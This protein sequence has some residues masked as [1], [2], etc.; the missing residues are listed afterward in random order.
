MNEIWMALAPIL[1]ADVLNPV[2]FAFMVY[3]VS[4]Q[5]PIINSTAILLGHTLAYFSAGIIIALGLE[6]ISVRLANP[7]SIDF[8]ISLLIGILLLWVAFRSTKKTD[9]QQNKKNTKLTP[10]KALCLGAVVNFVGI[11]F[12]LPYFA[13]LDQILKANLAMT[14]SLLILISYNLLYALPFVIVPILVIVIGER[15]KPLLQRINDLLARFSS[16]LMP[17]LLLLVGVFLIS[18][19]ITYFLTGKGLV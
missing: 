11:P 4:T 9:K 10:F 12:A 2:L 17:V 6:R 14:D 16:F 15:S 1:L 3:A 8:I 18:D 19:A 5:R 7:H 13:A